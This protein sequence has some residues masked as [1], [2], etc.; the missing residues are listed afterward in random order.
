[1]RRRV[2]R[3]GAAAHR[4]GGERRPHR[5]PTKWARCCGARGWT[6]ASAWTRAGC[7]ARA[8]ARPSPQPKG[9]PRKRDPLAAE[10]ERRRGR[11]AR[12]E[13]RL[14]TAERSIEIWGNSLRAAGHPARL[15]RARTRSGDRD[16]DRARGGIGARHDWLL[17]GPG[18]CT[19]H[20][21]SQPS[22]PARSRRRSPLVF[23]D[24]ERGAVLAPLH[25][26]RIVHAAPAQVYATLLDEGRYLSSERTVDRILAAGR[27]PRAAGSAA[28]APP[29]PDPSSSPRGRTR[30]GAGISRN[31]GVR[32]SGPPT[33]AR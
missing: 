23:S 24:E 22:A 2:A 3:R 29:T 7:V 12:L 32:L 1:M 17:P 14:A 18:R 25:S 20:R 30:S 5:R 27:G 6:A 15:R 33:S 26:E 8:P 9:R 16:G 31:V 11:V 28:P 13:A 19:R 10:N 21:S 4:R